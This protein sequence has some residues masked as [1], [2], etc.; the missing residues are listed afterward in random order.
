MDKKD[1]STAEL[2]NSLNN[3]ESKLKESEL[4]L[5]DFSE[6]LYQTNDNLEL[7]NN[8][9]KYLESDYRDEKLYNKVDNIEINVFEMRYLN[10]YGR[11]LKQR[12][13]SK[14]PSLYILLKPDK[15]GIKN[16]LINI[17]GYR[18][19]KKNH[20]FNIGYYLKNN[21]DL[22]LTGQ[23]PLIHYLFHGYKE[24]RDPNPD[25]DSNY[26]TRSNL[27]VQKTKINPLIHYSLYGNDEGR[28]TVNPAFNAKHHTN[29]YSDM[30]NSKLN[31]LVHHNLNKIEEEQET[32]QNLQKRILYVV[33]EGEGGTQFTN[34]D[35]MK[36]IQ[37]D[38]DIFYLTSD[39]RT[40]NLWRYVDSE[41][42]FIKSWR[43][44][45]KWSANN[46]YNPEFKE[47]YMEVLVEYKI[48]IVH[49][50]H[51]LQHTFDLVDAIDLLEIPLILSFH[52]FY[53]ICPCFTLL[54]ENNIYCA[55]K[56]TPGN[57][58]CS[59]L[60]SVMKDLPV[61]K[62]FINEWRDQVSTILSSATTLVTTSEV[63]KQIFISVY[64]QLSNKEF[65]IIE[66]GRD[67][68]TNRKHSNLYEIPSKDRPTKILIPGD[69][70]THK[71]ADFIKK[72]KKED[73]NSDL[74]FHFIGIIRDYLIDYG[75]YH[76]K[77]ERENFC[78]V[79]GSIKPSFIGI[80]SIWPETY[81]HT[82][83]EAWSCG[84]PVLTTKI[85]VLEARVNENGGGW[86]LDYKNPKNA[87][88]K[89]M[90]II[91]AP[92]EYAEVAEQA[93]N[94]IFKSTKQMGKEY[95]ELYKQYLKYD[96]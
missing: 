69:I 8:H 5:N 80:F 22:R 18:A 19:I 7:L 62:T 13:I 68:K 83:S 1:I 64:P 34:E 52:D 33:H 53:F 20:L 57:G 23:D 89:I 93:K 4:I 63:V 24:N 46:F 48:D 82:L 36:H 50:R 2:K 65:K 40:L 66:H 85:G 30:K 26:Y 70:N 79:V 92:E 84:V 77:Y 61:L 88:N 35:L 73:K 91:N 9:I 6:E 45:S 15:I 95:L 11:S 74:E 25:F 59:I 43:V 41:F 94:I 78:E 71:G 16:K 17:K 37:N 29:V 3:F 76:G 32:G 38:L 49:I 96:I 31:P 87:Y 12:L 14:F 67:F 51:L 86:L 10:N 55:G 58:Q 54:D 21:T 81:C 42:E 75:I 60:M 27:D 39:S 72:I 90:E 47:I 28:R 44:Q 56:C